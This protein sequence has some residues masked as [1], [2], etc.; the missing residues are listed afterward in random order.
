M[1]IYRI[2]ILRFSLLILVSIILLRL[3]FIQVIYADKFKAQAI[4][5]YENTYK[6]LPKRGD[7]LSS[8]S[9]PLVL[10]VPTYQLYA[11]PYLL[12]EADRSLEKV[13]S[14]V[15]I[16]EPTASASAWNEASIQLFDSLNNKKIRWLPIKNKLNLEQK[17]QIEALGLN[18][19]GFEEQTVRNYPE[20]SMAAQLIGFVGKDENGRDK[21]YFGLE[22]YYDLELAG[23]PEIVTQEKDLL[24]L[25]IV[26]GKKRVNKG[27]PGRTLVTSIDRAAQFII[28]EKL[29]EGIE[30]Y[31][32]VSGTVSIMDPDSGQILGMASFPSYDPKDYGESEPSL[33]KNPIIS[34]SF[35]PGSTFK[36]IVMASALN[37]SLITPDTIC[38][39]CASSLKLDK[40]VISTWDNK[41]HPNSTM[42][43]VLVHSDN[44]GMVFVGDLLGTEKFI[45]YYKAFGFNSETG[46]DLQEEISP[47]M[48]PEDTWTYID[49]ST[50]T[51]GQGIAVTPI[52]MLRAISVIANG[53]RLVTPRVV[54]KI[55]EDGREIALPQGPHKDIISS[56]AALLTTQ[57]MVEAVEKGEAKWAKPKNFQIAGKTGT[58]QIAVSGHYDEEK[59]IASFIGF[60]PAQ[61]PKFAMLVT[62]KEPKTSPW[63]S[64]TAAPLWFS[65]AKELLRLWNISPE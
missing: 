32:A 1:E 49:R 9:F 13:R 18:W 50:A 19:L 46:I 37:E 15:G 14:I 12:D 30:K 40:Y 55:I 33:F 7:I 61:N 6:I 17:S 53:G 58:A 2:R 64:E 8:D 44:V 41:Y 23:N 63:G 16:T 27:S 34:E 59:T 22:G 39:R 65:I 11:D 5:Q 62:L 42:S 48:K 35:E 25:P 3:F 57:M 4:G 21:G 10:S 43:E 54:D 47:P 20:S 38:T 24:G 51:F 29:K 28:Q 56:K 36:T 52:Q 26:I 60:A 31:E 45:N